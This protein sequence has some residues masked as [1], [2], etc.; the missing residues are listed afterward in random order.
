MM[1][2]YSNIPYSLVYKIGMM[3]TEFLNSLEIE[4]SS[5]FEKIDL[6]KVEFFWIKRFYLL[7]KFKKFFKFGVGCFFATTV[8]H[9]LSSRFIGVVMQVYEAPE[10]VVYFHL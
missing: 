1:V 2:T 7:L 8:I 10:G 5:D 4:S 3:Q 9:N 6:K